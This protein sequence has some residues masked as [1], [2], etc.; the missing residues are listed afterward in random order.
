[1]SSSKANPADPNS[2]EGGERRRRPARPTQVNRPQPSVCPICQ[3]MGFVLRDAEPGDA[4]FG[5]PMPCVCKQAEIAAREKGLMQDFGSLGPLARLTFENFDAEPFWLTQDKARNLR[6]A[7]EKCRAF[8]AKPQG[9]LLLTG[10]YGCGKTHLAAAIANARLAEQH[11]VL[12]LVL[13]DLLDHLR[14]TFG[15]NSEIQYDELF[16][17][18]R[19]APLLII[20]DLGAHSASNWAQEKLFQLLNHRYNAQLPTV[21]TTNQRLEQM[22]QRLRSRMVDIHL[23]ERLAITAPDFRAGANPAH[24]ELS[25]LGLHRNQNFSSFDVPRSDLTTAQKNALRQSVTAVEAFA[26]DPQG[27]L[28][29]TGA[30][31]CGKTHLAAA[32]A[33]FQMDQGETDVMFVVVPDLLDHLRAAF[34]PQSATPY[35]RR[36]D[37]IKKTPLLVL[38]DLG[39]ESATPWAKEKLFQ[40]LNYRYSAVLPTVITT[41]A[42]PADIDP[43]LLTRMADISRCRVIALPVPG[44]RG[45]SSQKESAGRARRG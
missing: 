20:D 45:S 36:F 1:M 23:V 2:E 5:K 25:S 16:E 18:V 24:S 32:V 34:S 42:A 22:D 27:W 11:P 7:F 4:D 44:Y 43:W 15:P 14:A 3:G 40:L 19:E 35:D 31:G 9:W 21:I 26:H 38:D 6:Q 33:N 30:Y 28:V 37:E 39:T 12:F 17:Q 10:T 8:A 41:S 29:L 13:A